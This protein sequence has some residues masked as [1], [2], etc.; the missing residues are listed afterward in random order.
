MTIA[1]QPAIRPQFRT[2]DG[3]SIRVAESEPHNTEALLLSPWPESLFA[4]QPTWPR[5]AEQAHLVAI[6]LPGF[7]HSQR[8]DALLSTRAMGEFIVRLADAFGLEKPHLVGPDIGTSAAL[9]AASTAPS[10]FGTLVFGSGRS[11]VPLQLGGVDAPEAEVGVVSPWPGRQGRYVFAVV[12]RFGGHA[13][14]IRRRRNRRKWRG[15]RKTFSNR[16]SRGFSARAQD[17][18][19]RRCYMR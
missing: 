19:G 9:F 5:L 7:G 12:G 11:A 2:V 3:L 18:H 13:Q 4:F 14:M 1:V 17:R 8:P 15:H 10:R 6:D 16:A